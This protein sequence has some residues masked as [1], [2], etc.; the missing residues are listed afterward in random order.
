MVYPVRV[1]VQTIQ[2]TQTTQHKK[3]NNNP[4][5][6]L[7][8]HFPKEDTQMHS[9][10]MRRCSASRTIGEML[11]NHNEA[12]PHPCQNDC[13]QRDSNS[14]IVRTQRKGLCPGASSVGRGSVGPGDGTEATEP[15]PTSA[16]PTPGRPPKAN[17]AVLKDIS[18][19]VHPSTPCG[20]ARNS[21]DVEASVCQ[22]TSG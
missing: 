6:D 3:K 10:H 11:P 13:P 14:F 18:K 22:Q 17:S 9:R 1:N 15:S 5:E 21:Q 7:T 16:N 19:D 2:R 12:S 8:R 4:T 20:I